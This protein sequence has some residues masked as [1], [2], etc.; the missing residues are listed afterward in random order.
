MGAG[1]AT[2]GGLLEKSGTAFLKKP[3]ARVGLCGGGGIFEK[4]RVVFFE[5]KRRP[6]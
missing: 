2:G 3:V 4:F 1:A 5:R 6:A